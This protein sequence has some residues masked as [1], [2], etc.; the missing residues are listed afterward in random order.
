MATKK[1]GAASSVQ[2]SIIVGSIARPRLDGGIL[3]EEARQAYSPRYSATVVTR[4][5][6]TMKAATRMGTACRTATSRTS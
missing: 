5:I 2:P 4:S 3:P 6:A 1:A